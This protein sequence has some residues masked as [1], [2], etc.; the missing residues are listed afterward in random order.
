MM[1]SEQFD[2]LIEVKSAPMSK[3]IS[4]SE[5]DLSGIR[6]DLDSDDVGALAVLNDHSSYR[7]S[8]VFCAVQQTRRSKP[9]S[10]VSTPQYDAG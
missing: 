9:G 7:C 5:R 3:S 4:L 6:V 8:M 2:L 10:Q 1:P